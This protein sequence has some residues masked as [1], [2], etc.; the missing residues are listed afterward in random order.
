[1][2][3]RPANLDARRFEA[4]PRE[5]RWLRQL[6]DASV[7]FIGAWDL[8]GRAIYLNRRGRDL[9]GL[10][11]VE[12]VHRTDLLDYFFAEDRA[13]VAHVLD[14][15]RRTGPSAGTLRFRHFTTGNAIPMSWESFMLSD[16]AGRPV[17][18]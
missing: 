15:T 18:I 17:A 11:T 14:R 7:D 1:M 3:E 6:A 9:V 12:A 13:E 10:E 2:D 8:G 16:E 5:W 4:E